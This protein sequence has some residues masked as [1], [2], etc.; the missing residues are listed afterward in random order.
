M[1]TLA[2]HRPAAPL[3][4]CPSP[5]T[6]PSLPG[7]LSFVEPP[8]APVAPRRLVGGPLRR[9][10]RCAATLCLRRALCAPPRVLLL[11]QRCSLWFPTFNALLLHHSPLPPPRFACNAPSCALACAHTPARPAA[12]RRQWSLTAAQ[13]LRCIPSPTVHAH[14]QQAGL[15]LAA[16]RAC[17]AGALDLPGGQRH[18]GARGCATGLRDGATS[19]RAKCGSAGGTRDGIGP[20]ACSGARRSPGRLRCR[21]A[22][23]VWSARQHQRQGRRRER[24]CGSG[25][26]KAR[27]APPRSATSAAT[28]PCRA[29]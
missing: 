13:A 27:A 24:D 16:G 20:A 10:A 19:Q 5:H 18:Y 22:R 3:R 11:P 26:A 17:P 7:F 14:G 23:A 28:L 4:A 8:L 1:C 9:L 15:G 12:R 29:R 21:G 25:A 2:E 6:P